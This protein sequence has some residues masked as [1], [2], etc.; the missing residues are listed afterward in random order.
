[1]KL[2]VFNTVVLGKPL[3][4]ALDIAVQVAEGL[5]KLAN[6]YKYDALSDLFQMEGE[7]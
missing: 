3:E 5:R 1:M 2:G 6:R 4:E 7:G